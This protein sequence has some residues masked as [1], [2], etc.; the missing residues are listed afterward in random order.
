M[1]YT[2]NSMDVIFEQNLQP[3]NVFTEKKINLIVK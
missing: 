2:K 1:Q 3:K